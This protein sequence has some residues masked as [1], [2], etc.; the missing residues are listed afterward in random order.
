MTEAQRVEFGTVQIAGVVARVQVF[1]TT[2]DGAMRGFLYHFT[3]EGDSW[4]SDCG[5]PL[6]PQPLRRLRGL[7]I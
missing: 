5:H 6:G 7:H 1:L 4:K 3:A 2:P